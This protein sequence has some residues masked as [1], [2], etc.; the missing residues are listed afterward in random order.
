MKLTGTPG[1]RNII[2]QTFEFLQGGLLI[3]LS[4][5][6]L[7]KAK[8]HVKTCYARYKQSGERRSNTKFS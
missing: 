5:C 7:I 1:G 8:H 3:S 4:N 6:D 2:I